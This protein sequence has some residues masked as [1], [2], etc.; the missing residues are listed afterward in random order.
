MVKETARRM[1]YAWLHVAQIGT[2]SKLA[3]VVYASIQFLYNHL[4]PHP[5]L[6][7]LPDTLVPTPDTPTPL[8]DA[9]TPEPDAPAPTL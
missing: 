2:V 7:P 1:S 3:L 5:M 9:P 4:L 6:Q 8:P